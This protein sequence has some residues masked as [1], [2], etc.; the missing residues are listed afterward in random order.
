V[1]APEVINADS[2][3]SLTKTLLL[4]QDVTVLTVV[5]DLPVSAMPSKEVNAT[6]VMDADSATIL[7]PALEVRIFYVIFLR[8]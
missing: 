7:V 3:T 2:L 5:L 6:V 4:L 1:N 8:L